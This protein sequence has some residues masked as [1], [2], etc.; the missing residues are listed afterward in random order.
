MLISATVRQHWHRHPYG[1]CRVISHD[2]TRTD[3]VLINIPKNAS[4]WIIQVFGSGREDNYLHNKPRWPRRHVVVLR[5]PVDRW[6]SGFAQAHSGTDPR[7]HTHY[8]N[9]GWDTVFSQVVFD[10]HTEPQTSYL[11]GLDTR[12]ITGFWCGSTLRQDVQ[13]WCQE[14]QLDLTVPELGQDS[15]NQ[16]NVGAWSTE[17]WTTD[18][19]LPDLG[20]WGV[21]AQVIQQEAREQLHRSP[22]YRRCLE[23][24]YRQDQ[25]L[26]DAIDFYRK[27]PQ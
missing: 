1:Q 21:S 5:D 23:T 15:D 6:I 12:D 3:W 14:Q 7:H 13:A 4:S 17:K 9:L 20:Y 26:I 27:E 18:L 25:E 19:T 24:F 8:R 22:R 11:S 2:A 16:F 10:N